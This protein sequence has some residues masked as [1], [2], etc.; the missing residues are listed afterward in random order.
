MTTEE[1]LQKAIEFIKSI[2]NIKSSF[3]CRFLDI[4]DLVID[5]DTNYSICNECGSTDINADY[6][7]SNKYSYLKF[8]DSEIL[9]ELSDKA[10][11]ILADITD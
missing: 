9:D 4:D 8:V 1:K 3:N 2:E 11:H 6:K 10:W 5:V 7:I